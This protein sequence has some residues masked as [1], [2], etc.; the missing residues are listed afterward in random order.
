VTDSDV[1]KNFSREANALPP[2]FS[3]GLS[4]QTHGYIYKDY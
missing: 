2:E 3:Y 1:N 4:G